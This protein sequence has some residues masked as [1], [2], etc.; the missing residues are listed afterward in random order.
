MSDLHPIF[1]DIFKTLITPMPETHSADVS[2]TK[3]M[4]DYFDQD[5]SY[6][7]V[8]TLRGLINEIKETP[9]AVISA[10]SKEIDLLEELLVEK[11]ICPICGDE[12]RFERDVAND[13]YV[14]YGDT[15]VKESNGGYLACESCGYRSDR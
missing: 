3:C 12:L 8:D 6:E 5:I 10:I 14:P 7:N 11:G 2:H 13:T 9:D 4:L 1:E 15:S